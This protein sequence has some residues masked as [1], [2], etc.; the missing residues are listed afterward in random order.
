MYGAAS[1]FSKRLAHMSD[2]QIIAIFMNK[3]TKGVIK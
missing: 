2:N 1:P 3:K